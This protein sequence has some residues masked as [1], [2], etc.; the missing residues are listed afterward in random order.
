MAGRQYGGSRSEVHALAG[1]RAC[2][3][4]RSRRDTAPPLRTVRHRMIHALRTLHAYG[5]TVRA[6]LRFAVA[7][8]AG[9]FAKG[10]LAYATIVGTSVPAFALLL[11]CIAHHPQRPLDRPA[12]QPARRS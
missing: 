3:P 10:P 8:L 9:A 2:V 4:V 12:R 7:S 5:C 11:H 6:V 1:W